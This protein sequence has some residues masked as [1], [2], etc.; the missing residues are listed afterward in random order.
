[1]VKPFWVKIDWQKTLL[2]HDTGES[3]LCMHGY[4]VGI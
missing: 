3:N 4:K 1:M 2:M